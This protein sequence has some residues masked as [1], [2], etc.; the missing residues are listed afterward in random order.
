MRLIS[1]LIAL[2]FLLFLT[3]SS[4]SAQVIGPTGSTGATGMAGPTGSTGSTGLRGPTG[5]TG[6]SGLMGPT[7]SMGPTGPVG[8]A[9]ETLLFDGGN[10]LYPNPTYTTDF[11]FQN[12]FLGFGGPTA[13]ISTQLTNQ[14][15]SIDPNGT[16]SI[17]LLGNVGIGLSSP[18]SLLTIDSSGYLQFKKTNVGVP[19]A[20]DCDSDTERGR[21]TIRTDSPRLYICNGA[22]RG[23]DYID[24][25]N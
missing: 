15:L 18:G 21:L 2:I 3:A 10:Y 20:A 9:G 11:R 6:S 5:A 25:R 12:L 8:P 19:P 7:G 17:F 4:V 1:Y 22:S 24:L 16:G 23:W 13:S 14:N